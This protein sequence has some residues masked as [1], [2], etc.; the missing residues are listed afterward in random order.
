MCSKI[1]ANLGQHRLTHAEL[2][3]V[4][5]EVG[6]Q[7]GETGFPY[8]GHDPIC[9][10]GDR[11]VDRDACWCAAS[12]PT[13]TGRSLPGFFVRIR[14]PKGRVL[15]KALLVPDRALQADQGG[16]YLLVVNAG[17]CRR[18]ALCRARR[19]RRRA[20]RHL[21][22]ARADD[23]VIVGDLWRVAP[24][25]EGDAAADDARRRVNGSQP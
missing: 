16:R 1:R 18:A 23:R 2:L 12:S 22:R 24:G 5:V 25:H 7:S 3:K 11:P 21:V 13:R 17:Q 9:G 6:L 20:S 14:L 10:A 19:A 4:P 8:Q 15:P